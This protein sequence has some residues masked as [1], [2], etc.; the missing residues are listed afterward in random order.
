MKLRR[1]YMILSMLL[2]LAAFGG[3]ANAQSC[4]SYVGEVGPGWDPSFYYSSNPAYWCSDDSAINLVFQADG[5]LVLYWGL[6]EFR[7][8]VLWASNT[9]RRGQMFELQT[10]ENL[11]I[12]D[13][14]FDP[15]WASGTDQ[16]KDA[17]LV[18]QDDGNLVLYSSY[19]GEPLWAT[20][21]ET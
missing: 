9:S 19:S 20:N 7:P 18:V 14:F 3:R 11:V 17:Y 5:N 2:M 10:D 16:R 21:T 4:S 15:V 1:S 8:L 12:Y 6:L 13:E